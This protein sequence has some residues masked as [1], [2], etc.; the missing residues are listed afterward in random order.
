VP[1][2]GKRVAILQSNYIPWKGYFDIIGAVD[3]FVI[4]DTVQ[5]TKNDWRNRNKIKTP[6]G[7]QWVTIPVHHHLAQTIEGT[8]VSDPRWAK[9]HWSSL[10]ANYARAAF[11][12]DCEDLFRHLYGDLASEESLSAINRRFIS[13]ICGILGINTRI[14]SSRKY[15]LA[16]NPTER[17]VGICRALGAS[18]YLSGPSARD[19]IDEARFD[20]ASI[21]LSYMDY[22]GYPE[23]RQLFG[24]FRHDVTILDL[25][26]NEGPDATGFMKSFAREAAICGMR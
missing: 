16:G 25:I 4:Y 18:E 3:E 12:P 13:E 19:Y 9:R 22:S 26:F 24:P 6:D 21:R 15:P 1:G 5:Y 10:V 17:L 8:K 2:V 20:E 14:T 11:F 23:Y 7:L